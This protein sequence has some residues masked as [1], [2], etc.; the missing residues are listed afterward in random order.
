MNKLD[1]KTTRPVTPQIYAYT[2]PEIPRH[3][4]WTKIGYTEQEVH[5]R[6][7]QQTH[8]ADVEY[9]LEWSGNAIYEDGS[10]ERFMYICASQG[11]NRKTAKIT[12]GFTL[13]VVIQNR[14]SM[15]SGR[16]MEY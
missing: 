1:I 4:G 15:N 9:E 5:K 13:R 14:C 11:L 10:G 16:I 2:T 12:N 8:T 6:I 3:K 7:R